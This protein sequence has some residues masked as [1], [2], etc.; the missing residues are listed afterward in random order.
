[1]QLS[2]FVEAPANAVF[3]VGAALDN[4]S[5]HDG[6]LSHAQPIVGRGQE[7]VGSS[8]GGVSEASEVSS[9]EADERDT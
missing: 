2:A 8:F 6:S 4:G 1:M 7:R 3:L 9:F 5:A